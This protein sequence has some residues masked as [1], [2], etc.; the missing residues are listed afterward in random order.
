MSGFTPYN[1]TQPEAVQTDLSEFL[2]TLE[3]PFSP[4]VTANQ[5]LHWAH[6]AKLTK[7]LRAHATVAA[8][9]TPPLGK[10]KVSLTWF[11]NTKHR[12]DADNIVP[13]L[14]ALC[15]G[16]VD[17]GVVVDDTPDLMVKTMPEIVYDKGGV[18]RMELRIEKL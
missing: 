10:C 4:T 11:V 1:H 17:A 2:T 14:K 9:R 8:H 5:R 12:R 16:L 7:A 18:P 3:F 15:D 6:K 13:T